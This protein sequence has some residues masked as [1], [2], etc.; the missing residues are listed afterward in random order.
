[1]IINITQV[2]SIEMY[3]QERKITKSYTMKQHR[4]V[5]ICLST[6]VPEQKKRLV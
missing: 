2:Y 4:F 1:M 3:Q 6:V 5:L